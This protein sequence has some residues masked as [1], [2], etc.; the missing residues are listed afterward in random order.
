MNTLENNKII[1][2]FMGLAPRLVSPD[3]YEYSDSPFISIRED[4]PEKVMEGIVKYAKY[5][6]DWN[7]LMPVVERIESM[8]FCFD[9]MNKACSISRSNEMIVDLNGNDFD[10]K[11]DSVY[12]A[13]V[14]FLEWYNN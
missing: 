5:N 2:Q 9:I 14:D 3:V 11:I 7:W 1:A 4:N 12:F 13:C 10:K 8:G 6:T